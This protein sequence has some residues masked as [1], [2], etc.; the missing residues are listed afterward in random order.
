MKPGENFSGESGHFAIGGMTVVMEINASL[1][2]VIFDKNPD[3]EFYIEESYPLDWTYPYLEPHGLILKI[4]RQPVPE[5]SGEMLDADAKYWRNL[6]NGMIGD[7]LTEETSVKTV[8]EFVNKVY[9]RKDLGGFTGDPAFVQNEDAGKIF[10]K[11]R[12]SIAGLYAWRIG[13]VAG[14]SPDKDYRARTLEAG[15]RMEAAADFAF[16]QAFAFCPS[17]REIVDRY[18]YFLTIEGRPEDAILVAQTASQMPSLEKEEAEH[19]RTLVD[20]LKM[21]R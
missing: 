17:S 8:A 14:I 18:T 4:S 12:S 21:G 20:K 16:R 10:G 19:F 11:L 3:R 9:A 7:W 1:V 5:W 6:E 2:K 15:R 13:A